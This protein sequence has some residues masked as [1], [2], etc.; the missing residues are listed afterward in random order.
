MATLVDGIRKGLASTNKA[1]QGVQKRN[2]NDYN[3]AV[4]HL[5]DPQTHARQH[6]THR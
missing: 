4:G 6:S 2:E 5:A 1:I 3:A